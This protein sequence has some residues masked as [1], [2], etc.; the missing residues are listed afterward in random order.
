MRVHVLGLLGSAWLAGCSFSSRP[1][2]ELPP[3]A[4]ID[5]EI[6]AGPGVDAA[7]PAE[8]ADAAPVID[9]AIATQDCVGA[10]VNVCVGRPLA[11][12][13]LTTQTLN[14]ATSPLCAGYQSTPALDACVIAG[15][16]IT[17]PG[18]T[19]VTV[20]GARPLVLVSTGAI[21]ISGTLDAASHRNGTTGPAADLGS[22][23]TNPT[24]PTVGPRG[25]GGG[26][27]GG[28][29]GAAGN[30]GGNGGSGGIGR[31]AGSA[32]AP[33]ALRGGC[34]GSPGAGDSAGASASGGGA[35]LLIA[36]QIVTI[37][38]AVNASG[39][40]G[41]GARVSGGGGGGGSGGM[42]VLDAA[43]VNVPGMCFANGGGGGEG[44]NIIASGHDGGESSAPSTAAAGGKLGTTIGG[45]G[46]DGGSGRTPAGSPGNNGA[47]ETAPNGMVTQLGGG[48]GGGGGAGVIK[49]F[50]SEKHNTDDITRVAPAPNN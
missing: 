19:T 3:D 36:Q 22:C 48:G 42:I 17:I 37:D 30:N 12:I 43:T 24:L 11:P 13:I 15:S 49:V 27:S 8:P 26:G 25:D 40:A 47:M 29:L 33:T 5:I 16:A 39:A 9:G 46:G 45:D 4:A 23:L 21:T 28:S 31:G 41:G 32:S 6:D 38:G 44:S 35:V 10:F 34:P 14:T 18:N 50:A 2:A 20:T 7:E 1:L